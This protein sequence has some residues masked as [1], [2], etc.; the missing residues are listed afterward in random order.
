MSQKVVSL[1]LRTALISQL[2]AEC[3]EKQ[4]LPKFFPGLGKTIL[5]DEMDDK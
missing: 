4:V 1:Y 5:K 2:W 3:L